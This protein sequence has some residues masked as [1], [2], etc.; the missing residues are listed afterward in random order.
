MRFLGKHFLVRSQDE[1]ATARQ[2]TICNVLRPQLYEEL[3][4]LLRTEDKN[5][6]TLKGLLREEDTNY[7]CFVVK[8]YNSETGLSK[9]LHENE[10][11]STFLVQGPLG[12]RLDVAPTGIYF[13]FAAGTGVLPFMDLV[14]Q[15]ALANLGVLFR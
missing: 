4:R 8:N 6:Q 9:K 2:Y 11:G 14:A 1:D 10:E 7:M 13:C 15:L 12:K 3:I 5:F